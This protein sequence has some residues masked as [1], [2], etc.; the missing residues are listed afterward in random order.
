MW[1]YTGFWR[2]SNARPMGFNGPLRIPLSEIE[3]YCRL[4]RLDFSQSQDFLFFIERLDN[5]WTLFAQKVR[6]EQERKQNQQS[7]SN[8]SGRR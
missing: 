3:A 4:R 1:V 5:A 7:Q 2:L 6:A 8:G